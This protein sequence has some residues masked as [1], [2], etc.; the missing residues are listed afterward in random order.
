MRLQTQ[1]YKKTHTVNITCIFKNP[2]RKL[3]FRQSLE[4]GLHPQIYIS[5]RTKVFKQPSRQFLPEGSILFFSCIKSLSPV[6]S[7]LAIIRSAPKLINIIKLI[8][9]WLKKKDVQLKGFKWQRLYLF[10]FRD[11]LQTLKRSFS[12]TCSHLIALCSIFGD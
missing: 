5:E 6:P 12:P 7:L 2:G 9:L 11:Q 1:T 8:N 3:H 10:C 4:Y